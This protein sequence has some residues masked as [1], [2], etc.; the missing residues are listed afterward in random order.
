MALKWIKSFVEIILEGQMDYKKKTVCIIGCKNLDTGMSVSSAAFKD[1]PGRRH[2]IDYVY[3]G[4]V[5]YEWL[6]VFVSPVHIVE[7][8]SLHTSYSHQAR[9]VH[10]ALT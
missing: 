2:R 8:V 9:V 3:S 4:C 5:A 6:P 7:G 10:L 1:H